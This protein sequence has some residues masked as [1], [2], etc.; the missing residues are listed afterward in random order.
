[1][2]TVIWILQGLIAVMF[3]MAGFMKISK[4]K[5]ELKKQSSMA[6]VS[7]VSSS[8]LKIIGVLEL[9]AAIG[10]IVP[11]LTGI[12][13]WLTPFAAVGLAFTMIGA[14]ALHLRRGDGPQALVP[15]VMLLLIASFVAYGRFVLVPA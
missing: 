2:N 1:M 10:L 8:K 7:D 3:A 12:Q 4:P 13:V 11:Q 5:E 9:L 6:W 15:D 14:L